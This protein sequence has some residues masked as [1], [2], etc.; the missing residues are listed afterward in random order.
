MTRLW[1]LRVAGSGLVLAAGLLA[2]EGPPVRAQDE[3]RVI[4]IT[5]R[6]FEFSP[7][8]V[9]LAEQGGKPEHNGDDCQ[10]QQE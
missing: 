6:R 9:T 8:L 1:T 3:P 2:V 7:N 4:M 10:E 5:A